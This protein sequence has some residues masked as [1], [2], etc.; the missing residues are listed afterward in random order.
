MTDTLLWHLMET[1]PG[2]AAGGRAPAPEKERGRAVLVRPRRSAGS[3]SGTSIRLRRCA[4][5]PTLGL[6]PPAHPRGSL[7]AGLQPAAASSALGARAPHPSAPKGG[8]RHPVDRVCAMK[9]II[10]C[11]LGERARGQRATGALDPP[12]PAR[13]RQG[14]R[15]W[16]P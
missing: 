5:R 13:G 1:P 11:D 3:R 14:L 6:G 9:A 10:D 7:R 16:T 8:S 15:E 4:R 2:P 12:V